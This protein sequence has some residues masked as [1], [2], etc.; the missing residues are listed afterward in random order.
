MSRQILRTLF[1]ASLLA[2]TALGGGSSFAQENAAPIQPPRLSHPLPDFV[3]LVKQVKPA[4]VSITVKM[5]DDGDEGE[6]GGMGGHGAS[7]FGNMPFPM[8]FPFGQPQAHP[9]TIE[10]RGSG[11]LIDADGTIVTNNHVVK[12]AK[13][14][15]VTLDDGTTLPARIIGRDSR[16]DLAVVRIKSNHKLPFIALGNSDDA[17]PGAWVV[18][19]G[20]PFGL[21]GTVTAGIVSA[22]GRDIGAG[23][24]DSFIQTDAPINMGNSGGP[25]FMQNGQVVGVNTMIFSTGGGSV[26]IGFAIPSNT[27]KSVVAQLE[28]SGHVTRG[29]IGVQAQGV[30][31]SMATALHLPAGNGDDR[32]ALV[33]SVEPDS[34]AQNAGIQPGDVIAQVNN[35]P[36][37]NQRD[38]AITVSQIPPGDEAHLTVLRNGSTKNLTI[39]V[40]TLTT[41]QAS[42]RVGNSPQGSPSLGVGLQALT[43]NLR[44]QLSLPDGIRGAVIAEVK[45]GSVAEQAGLQQGDVIVGVGDTAVNSPNEATRAIRESLKNSQAVALRIIRD[46]QPAFIAVSPSQGQDQAPSDSNGDDDNQ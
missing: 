45:P 14:V 9:R 41:D 44:Q 18:A 7:P 8:P 27:V 10:A 31:P 22:R 42:G 24:Y 32:G 17:Q 16:S 35:H 38:L 4:V 19:V 37:G 12:N 20:N 2:G 25:L 30:T 40:A 21:S 13:S 36:I 3:D 43:P 1:A 46:G 26:G 29:F 6:G 5:T 11:F 34:P 33:A 15:S 28:K 39:K 23:N